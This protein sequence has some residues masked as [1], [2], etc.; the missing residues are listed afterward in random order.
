MRRRS[1]GA[2]SLYELAATLLAVKIVNRSNVATARRGGI[3]G[4]HLSA[5]VTIGALP[6]G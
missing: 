2:S 3:I 1:I 5:S 6:W 4:Q